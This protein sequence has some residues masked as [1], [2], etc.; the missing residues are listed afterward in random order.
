[1]ITA[2]AY[3]TGIRSGRDKPG[4]HDNINRPRREKPL[5]ELD[6]AWESALAE[7][8][9]RARAAGRTDIEDYL[10]LRRQNDLLRRTAIDWLMNTVAMLA[11]D[12]NR[13]GAGIQIERQESHRFT[14]GHATMVGRQLTLRNGVRALMVESGWPRT[15]RDG[16]MRGGG[17]ARGHIK[18]FGR[19]RSNAELL[20]ERTASGRPQWMLIEPT[21]TRSPLTESQIRDHIS[22]LLSES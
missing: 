3:E 16:F 1:M 7:A 21:G 9:Q 22:I 18:H 13:A 14:V 11:G 12:A 4:G 17:L 20:L 2:P 10:D 8:K 6:E 15:P 19:K 5:S